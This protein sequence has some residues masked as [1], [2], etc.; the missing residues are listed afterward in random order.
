VS[1]TLGTAVQFGIV[2]EEQTYK[3]C[4]N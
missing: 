4:K 3:G 2:Q 1:H